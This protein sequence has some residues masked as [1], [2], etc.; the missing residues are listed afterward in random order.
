MHEDERRG[1]EETTSMQ[2]SN[3]Q[4]PLIIVGDCADTWSSF[5]Y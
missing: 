3:N 4:G 5:H 2:A 1:D